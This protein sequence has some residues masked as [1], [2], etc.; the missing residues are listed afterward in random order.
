MLTR[1]R[2]YLIALAI[3]TAV[4]ACLR[5]YGLSKGAPYHHFH[6]DEHFVFVGADQL[7]DSMRK[8]AESPKFFMYGPLPMYL[9]NIVRSVY[10]LVAGPLTLSVPDDGRIVHAAGAQRLRL[11]WEPR[12]FHSC[13]SSRTGSPDASPGWCRPRCSRA[14]CCT[15]A[16]RI[17]SPSTSPW[18]SFAW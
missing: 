10:E 17:S 5:F 3:I 8:A 15:C 11:F 12:R 9:V 2:R 16:I 18:C 1:G 13:F 6:I 14:P 7:R 4:G